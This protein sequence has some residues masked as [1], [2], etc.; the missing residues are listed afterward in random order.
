[1]SGM[2]R[3]RRSPLKP[4]MRRQILTCF[5]FLVTAGTACAADARPNGELVWSDEF[6]GQTL[7]LSKWEF[8]VNA[9]G[10]GNN[11]LQYYLTNN[12]RL[13]DGFLIIEARQERYTGPEGTR[14]YT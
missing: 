1:M 2:G 9:S 6:N 4:T 12:V 7:D 10:G 11:E 13:R 14:S 3:K 8:E 5:A